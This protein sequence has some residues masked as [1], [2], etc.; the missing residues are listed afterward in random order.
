MSILSR[1]PWPSHPGASCDAREQT[2]AMVAIGGCFV[3]A[4][5]LVITATMLVPS[6]EDPK[7]DTVGG[8][9]S[10]L[11]TGSGN[12]TGAGNGNGRGLAGD[13]PGVAG[14]GSGPGAGGTVATAN[15]ASGEAPAAS[16]NG[17]VSRFS[18]KIPDADE[19][20]DAP[21]TAAAAGRKEGRA[22]AG[23]GGTTF[24]GVPT[25]AKDIVY[26]LDFS[27]SMSLAPER[28]ELVKQELI[29]SIGSLPDDRRFSVVIFGQTKANGARQIY[30]ADNSDYTENYVA[31]PPAGQL[32]RATNPNKSE[33]CKWVA[34]R[35][36]DGEAG[37][38]AGPAMAEV[39]RM[40]PQVVY[41]LTD[42]AFNDPDFRELLQVIEK[43]DPGHT[44]KINTVA[45]TLTD[46]AGGGD[47][48][49]LQTL[50]GNSGGTY[51]RVTVGP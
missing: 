28:P 8:I 17:E 12:G 14:Q 44:V 46:A 3:L 26:L 21:S 23:G 39:L 40:R 16:E 32:V 15:A 42:G 18:F 5:G 51:R 47:I 27:S 6:G 41:V 36:V 38:E 7:T 45:F 29:R 13:G 37:S 31:M 1:I 2:S 9:G 34:G 49:D 19:T 30:R 20:T 25:E 43:Q 11:G 22:G 4:L 48:R 10:G 33:A 24:M 35:N 50:A